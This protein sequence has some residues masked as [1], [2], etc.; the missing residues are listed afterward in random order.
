MPTAITTMSAGSTVPSFSSTPVTP[1]SSPRICFVCASV[2]TSMPRAIRSAFSIPPASASS[3]RSISVAMRCTTVTCMPPRLSPC[4]ASSPSSPPPITTARPP[5]A[6][7][8]CMVCTSAT[9]RNPIT[10]GRSRPTSGRMNGSDP[11]ATS[12]RSYGRDVPCSPCTTR[13]ARSTCHTRSPAISSIP[14]AAYQAR[15]LITMS[16]NA[17]SPASSGLSMMRL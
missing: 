16:S 10:P 14:F 17:F 9:S 6:A 4:A 15:S 2:S 13:A 8:A 7:A 5:F 12:S 1:S 11:V 3:C